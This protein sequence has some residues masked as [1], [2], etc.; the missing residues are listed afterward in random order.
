MAGAV[1]MDLALEN[2]IDTDP[3]H[4]FVVDPAPTGDDLLDPILS[5]IAAHVEVRDS[6]FWLERVAGRGDRIN[7]R[8]RDRLVARGI[9]EA[10]ANGL[11]F[12]SRPVA[13]TRRYP[14]ADKTTSEDVQFRIMRL[15]F[16]E[17]VPDPRDLLI[18]SLA[19]AC[20]VFES[21]L[22]REE[23]A[24]VRDRIDWIAGLD[25]VGREVAAAARRID[26]KATT[27][28]AAR[29]H[30]EIPAAAGWPLAG[31]A[32]DMAGDLTAFLAR[33][34]RKHGPI[35]R[36]RA[37]NRRFIAFA[38]PDAIKFLTKIGSTHLR[39][40]ELWRDF[41]FATGTRHLVVGMDGS[42]HLRMRKLLAKAYSPKVIEARLGDFLDVTRR[43]I[44]AWPRDRPVATQQAM[45]RIVAEQTGLSLT[46][47]SS[48]E[49]VD[50]LVVFLETLLNVHIL[51]R[52][53][54]LAALRPRFRRARRGVDKLYAKILDVHRPEIRDGKPPDFIDELLEMNRQDPQFLSETDYMMAFLGPYF[55]G[56][57]TASSTCSYML[58]A[59]LKHPDLLA[60]V[61]A[62]VDA[63]FD[64][65]TPAVE[66][67]RVLD[68]THRVVLETLRMYPVV[69]VVMRIVSNAF[70]FRGFRIP[71][72]AQIL[73]GTSVGHRLPECFPEPERFDI[74][75]F[76]QPPPPGVRSVRPGQT[77]LPRKRLRR[78][79]GHVHPGNHRPRGRYRVRAARPPPPDQAHAGVPS[80]R[81]VPI[82]GD[83]R[84]EAWGVTVRSLL[85]D[86]P[87]DI[88]V[89]WMQEALTASG[90]FGAPR[91]DSVEVDN[92]GTATN[93]FGTVLRCR[94]I[95]RDDSSP[96][97]GT[98]IVKLPGT[99]GKA[100]RFARWLSLHKREY[101]YYRCAAA[102]APMRSPSLYYGAFEAR[103]HRFVLVLE[104][105][106][107]M[108]TIPQ[109]VGVEDARARLALQE[110]ARMHGQY[111]NAADRPPL[112][113][114]YDTLNTRCARILQTVY[115]ICLPSVL[116]HFSSR[117][118]PELRRFA[119]ALGPRVAAHFANIAT[120]PMTLV[121]GDY[122]AENMFFVCSSAS[123]A[124]DGF[125][126][127][128][129][130][131]CG[132][133]CGLYDVAY[134]LATSVP[135]D[136][137]RRIEREA[138]EEYHD[139]VCRMGARNWTF[140]DC[141]RSYRQNI[142]GAFVA[143]ILGCG[144]FDVTDRRRCDLATALLDRVLSAIEDLDANE[145]LPV[146]ERFLTPGY[147][148]STLSRWGYSAYGLVRRP[149]RKKA[150]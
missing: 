100:L 35:F 53:P 29:S 23:L 95:A 46:G 51:R 105:M 37:F 107:P 120:T 85:C 78:G 13:R 41:S 4:L 10:E 93:V 60:Q 74:E 94:L 103:D 128:D 26:P 47:I 62:E 71:A 56:L 40:H 70:D 75:R 21:I 141:W 84:A 58:Y 109:S 91:V 130:Q 127:I 9:L 11:V 34:Y 30:E 12:L 82:S 18:V 5:D 117:F 113:S 110:A 133:G 137:R 99:D 36:V 89:A 24:G 116:E 17:D 69:P 150:P 106:H 126:A 111:W 6:A 73:I 28:V 43:S 129:W 48:R 144:G 14:V 3:D 119:E 7:S 55:V 131:G 1:L 108:E 33:E 102:N 145:F 142:L 139:I 149:G 83:R 136:T 114:L 122:R 121:H 54:K 49:H 77:P 81:L 124:K 123:G 27:E 143:C 20:G 87:Q 112:S 118:S 59:L 52:W 65:G 2:R 88:T 79:A 101:D 138:L 32:F 140:E 115:L 39:T 135:V 50:D 92:L 98:V 42:E 96:I 8:A 44:A 148:F 97:P 147:A 63:V 38:G 57:D 61:R 125:A 76:R 132:S 64:R 31:N 25:L 45:Q 66:D 22:S 68:V 16:S 86:S 72:G 80:R 134:F 67:L 104:D 15:I 19:A 90:L 146:R